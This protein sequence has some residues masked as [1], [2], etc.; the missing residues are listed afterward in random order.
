[1]NLGVKKCPYCGTELP[2]SARFCLQCG[3]KVESTDGERPGPAAEILPEG[4]VRC[5]Q[6]NRIADANSTFR[7]PL[8]GRINLCMRH[9]VNRRVWAVPGKK[10]EIPTCCEVCH[11]EEYARN[12]AV[13]ESIKKER[14]CSICRLTD[15]EYE[16]KAC[17]R[18][19]CAK[20]A[21]ERL[22]VVKVHEGGRTH[23]V[24]SCRRCGQI[25]NQCISAPSMMHP[26]VH[27]CKKCGGLAVETPGERLYDF[28]TRC[29]S[30]GYLT[31]YAPKGVDEAGLPK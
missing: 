8:C 4:A 7:C 25:C 29:L 11:G 16:C 19:F 24:L 15:C 9:L 30:K 23:S 21:Q 2:A 26:T 5:P 12:H 18:H 14:S 17:G 27:Q 10:V 31:G 1:L 20:H 28:L 3:E 22:F 13:I 6:C